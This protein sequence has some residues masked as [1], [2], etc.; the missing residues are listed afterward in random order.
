MIIYIL[1]LLNIEI[2]QLRHSDFINKFADAIMLFPLIFADF[3]LFVNFNHDFPSRTGLDFQS[4]LQGVQVSYRILIMI[5][6]SQTCTIHTIQI[7]NY[8]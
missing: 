2:Y 5:I 6:L 3:T 1:L 8:I 4:M 7:F